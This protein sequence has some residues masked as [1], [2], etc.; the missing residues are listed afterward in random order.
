[1]AF[2]GHMTSSPCNWL[3][4]VTH[5]L[6][7]SSLMFS[8]QTREEKQTIMLKRLK[9]MKTIIKATEICFIIMLECK[10]WPHWNG[11][12][13]HNVILL[14]CPHQDHE[15]LCWIQIIFGWK[16]QRAKYLCCECVCT[17]TSFL[18]QEQCLLYLNHVWN[19]K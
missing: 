4:Q 15:A 18:Q 11:W 5:Q 14:P 19:K 10:P 17:A 13:S 16:K 12:N 3:M 7:F 8:G 9:K 1:M 2:W 6:L